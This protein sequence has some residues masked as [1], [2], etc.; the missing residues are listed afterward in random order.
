[1]WNK[2]SILLMNYNRIEGDS[3]EKKV[4]LEQQDENEKNFN[5]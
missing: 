3:G 5:E 2:K 1:M 4:R